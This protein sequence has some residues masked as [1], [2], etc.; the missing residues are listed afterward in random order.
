MM[1]YVMYWLKN[2]ASLGDFMLYCCDLEVVH[3]D[4]TIDVGLL[5][6]LGD[7]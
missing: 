7:A 1:C 3:I 6:Q 2:T 4:F 5:M